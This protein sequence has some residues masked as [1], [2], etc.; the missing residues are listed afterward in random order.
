MSHNRYPANESADLIVFDRIAHEA[1]SLKLPLHIVVDSRGVCR[2]I[3]VGPLEGSRFKDEFYKIPYRRINGWRLIS[4]LLHNNYKLKPELKEAGL[5]FELNPVS[6]LRFSAFKD[7]HGVRIAAFWQPDRL[8]PTGW[9]DIETDQLDDLCYR[10]KPSSILKKNDDFTNKKVE[11]RVLLLTLIGNDRSKSE[12]ELAELEGLVRSAGA[13]PVGVIS[14]KKAGF[15]PQTIW[16]TG[17]LQQAALEVRRYSASKVITDCELTPAQARN[18]ENCLNCPV[19]DRSELI[20]DIFAQR[21]STATG[22]LQ[23]E[24][25]QLRY[26]LPRLVGRGMTLSRQ[27]GGIGTRGPGETQLEKDRR[28][29]A[30]RI[31]KLMRDLKHVKRH[32]AQLKSHRESLP[33]V[34]LIGYTN[35]GKSTLLNALCKL[36]ASRKVNVEDKLFATLDLT[37][38]RMSLPRSGASPNELL[39]TDTVGFIRELP[40]P[41]VEAFK[42]TLEE[43]FEADLL[44]LIVDLS[45]P[46]WHYQLNTVNQLLDSLGAQSKR[47]LVANQID[48]CESSSLELISKIDPTVIYISAT[49]G[50]GLQGLKKWLQDQF[51]GTHSLKNQ[52]MAQVSEDV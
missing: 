3:W 29:I 15:Q 30:R 25:A 23:V 5:I 51:W 33:R 35:V 19:M 22:R 44:L 21:A 34:A 46:D 17:K 12:R 45:N 42:A 9:S 48:C 41:L 40:S 38:R 32:R 36:T 1:L 6:W 4:C 10:S 49:S 24:L 7:A 8:D 18:L 13:Q 37:T 39:I 27:G 11:E 28:A 52:L 16:G 26:R 50:A 2:L 43:T 20:L 47:Q 31:E 14:Q